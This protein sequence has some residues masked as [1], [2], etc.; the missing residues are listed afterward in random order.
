MYTV[1]S[2]SVRN[3]ADGGR[4]ACVGVGCGVQCCVLFLGGFNP[5]QRTRIEAIVGGQKHW[6]WAILF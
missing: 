2:C 5:R 4:G 6:W 1:V 3:D